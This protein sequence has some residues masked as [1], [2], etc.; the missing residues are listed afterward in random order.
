MNAVESLEKQIED[1]AASKRNSFSR[2]ILA[3]YKDDLADQENPISASVAPYAQSQQKDLSKELAYYLLTYPRLNIHAIDEKNGPI[4]FASL[5][6]IYG[7]NVFVLQHLE[8]KKS[9]ML[10]LEDIKT[11]SE[12]FGK[13]KQSAVLSVFK[14]TWHFTAYE[15]GD[16]RLIGNRN[17]YLDFGFLKSAMT[18]RKTYGIQDLLSVGFSMFDEYKKMPGSL[19]GVK[20]KLQDLLT[21]C[22]MIFSLDSPEL[23]TI[24]MM[25]PHTLALKGHTKI[26]ESRFVGKI[27]LAS[28]IFEACNRDRLQA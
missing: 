25:G 5:E 26:V 8:R 22:R 16:M 14:S 3:S 9:L 23:S 27:K 15:L 7:E 4:P 6:E 17:S 28:K 10:L 2:N 18:L 11:F 12:S 19:Y 1:I 13:D 20:E 24:T 21:S